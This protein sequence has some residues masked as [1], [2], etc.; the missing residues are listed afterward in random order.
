M[1]KRWLCAVLVVLG[2]ICAGAQSSPDVGW[3]FYGNDAGGTRYSAARQID[4]TNV[5]HLQLAWTYRTGALDQKTELTRKTTFEATRVN[6]SIEY[7][8]VSSAESPLGACDLIGL[9]RFSR[10]CGTTH[11][12]S[13][14]PGCNP[15]S[16]RTAA[17]AK[18]RYGP[19][20]LDVERE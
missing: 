9:S 17:W 4:R 1:S 2:S 16:Q 15:G 12:L 8:E 5:A 20:G 13:L 6:L 19:A 11:L 7:S 3:P 10:P 18:F 14:S